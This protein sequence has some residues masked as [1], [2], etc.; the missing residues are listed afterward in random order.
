MLSLEYLDL[1]YNSFR[2][3]IPQEWDL[4]LCNP[5]LSLKQINFSHNLLVGAVPRMLLLLPGL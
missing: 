4:P 2:G 5:V 3:E 1:S